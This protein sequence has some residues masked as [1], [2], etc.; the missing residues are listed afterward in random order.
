MTDQWAEKRSKEMAEEWA[1]Q[2]INVPT[3]AALILRA[4]QEQRERDMQQCYCFGEVGEKIAA[5]I[6]KGG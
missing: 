2:T 4:M 3:L 5:A 1:A 6:R